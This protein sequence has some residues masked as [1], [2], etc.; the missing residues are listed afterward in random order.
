MST[1]TC[2]AADGRTQT[3][4]FGHGAPL[5]VRAVDFN[6]LYAEAVNLR[7]DRI[8]LA[9]L[10]QEECVPDGF[11]GVE[12]DRYEFAMQAATEAGRD[13]PTDDDCLEGLRRLIDA[14]RLVHSAVG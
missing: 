8:Y 14:A 7:K 13:E 3:F 6:S 12:A 9:W 10:L 4:N 1:D 11:V 5:M 2:S